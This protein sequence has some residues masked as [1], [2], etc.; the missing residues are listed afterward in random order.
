MA[1]KDQNQKRQGAKAGLT[2]VAPGITGRPSEEYATELG[3]GR[4]AGTNQGAGA[5]GGG[6]AGAG[7]TGA[8]LAGGAGRTGRAAGRQAAQELNEFATEFGGE[9]TGAAKKGAGNK[10]QK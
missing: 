7:A 8:G 3:A 9:T 4:T 2:T 5:A 1:K 6:M 10:K